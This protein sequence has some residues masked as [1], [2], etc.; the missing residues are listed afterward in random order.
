MTK[1]LV[2]SSWPFNCGGSASLGLCEIQV[3]VS[4]VF[5]WR[6][7]NYISVRLNEIYHLP[8]KQKPCSSSE[9]ALEHFNY[10]SLVGRWAIKTN[11]KSTVLKGRS[12]S[13][14]QK[15]LP[16]G[17]SLVFQFRNR[18]QTRCVLKCISLT[19]GKCFKQHGDV[20]SENACLLVFRSPISSIPVVARKADL[21]VIAYGGPACPTMDLDSLFVFFLFPFQNFI[22]FIECL[23][24]SDEHT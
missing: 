12:G 9:G 16:V 10:L 4:L 3:M 1:K 22:L 11:S 14:C 8:S 23:K 24:A 13:T 15:H 6:K 19:A 2:L 7:C 20:P 18:I 21:T 5:A 17:A